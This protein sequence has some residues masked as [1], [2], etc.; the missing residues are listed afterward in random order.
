MEFL[1]NE[2]S[3]FQA[4]A[5]F[6]KLSKET[7]RELVEWL[8]SDDVYKRAKAVTVLGQAGGPTVGAKLKKFLK[9]EGDTIAFSQAIKA[10]AKWEVRQ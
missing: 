9:T 1:R 4:V 5:A 6:R 7:E 8:S 3:G 2:E 10:L